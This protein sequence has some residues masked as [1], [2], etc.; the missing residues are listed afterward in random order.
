MSLKS[1]LEA[2]GNFLSSS[3]DTSKPILSS[4]G[5]PTT[6]PN[7]TVPVVSTFK[8][9]SAVAPGV[10]TLRS[11]SGN[12]LLALVLEEKRTLNAALLG[13]TEPVPGATK[14]HKINK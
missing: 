5:F 9:T 2:T 12:A 6:L 13:K 1:L 10:N 11:A 14:N 4:E 8:T 3:K 7:T